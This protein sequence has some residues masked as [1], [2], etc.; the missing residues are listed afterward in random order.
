[1]NPWRGVRASPLL[2]GEYD[3]LM[4]DL[5]TAKEL[6]SAITSEIATI[7]TD[8]PPKGTLMNSLD[9]DFEVAKA[10]SSMPEIDIATVTRHV[11]GEVGQNIFIDL[12]STCKRYVELKKELAKQVNDAAWITDL[13]QCRRDLAVHGHSA[14]RFLS[15]AFRRAKALLAS[16]LTVPL[17]KSSDECLALVDRVIQSTTL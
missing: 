16:L 2:P 5:T 9:A 15:P 1:M 17:P 8:F 12:I 13:A 3:Q 11:W 14:I 6:Y 4:R 7:E 10:L